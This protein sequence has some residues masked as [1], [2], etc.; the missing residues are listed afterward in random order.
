MCNLFKK[1]IVSPKIYKY[2]IFNVS[3]GQ[4]IKLSYFLK[5]LLSSI[6][7]NYE[8]KYSF[9]KIVNKKTPSDAIRFS[10][11]NNKKINNFF[12]YKSKITLKN[13]INRFVKDY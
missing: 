4:A 6:K 13:G 7:K 11:G 3:N 2:E 1:I 10:I 5:I 12:K 9:S 8:K